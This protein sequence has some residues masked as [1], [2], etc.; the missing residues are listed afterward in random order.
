MRNKWTVAATSGALVL[1]LACSWSGILDSTARAQAQ[2]AL[3]RALIAWGIARGLNGVISIAQG[4][5]IALQPAGIGITL[6]AGQILDPLNDLVERFSWLALFAAASLGTQILLTEIFQAAWLNALISITVGVY[7]VCLWWKP[8]VAPRFQKLMVATLFLRFFV[9]LV[10]LASTLVSE[11]LVRERQDATLANLTNAS[12]TIDENVTR[13]DAQSSFFDRLGQSVD[14]GNQIEALGQ[15][16]ERLIGDIVDLFVTFIVQT[17]VL[18]LLTA[19]VVYI[20]L[21]AL[22]RWL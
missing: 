14:V 15:R 18:P 1:A 7:L 13:L 8:D 17:I 22:W 16:V 6:T 9:V 12:A 11:H 4:T 21:R 20:S 3:E 5:E 10:A 19:G 2:P